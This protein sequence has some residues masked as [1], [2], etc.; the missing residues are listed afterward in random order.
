[1]CFIQG[2]NTR[3]LTLTLVLALLMIGLAGVRLTSASE[4]DV[5]TNSADQPTEL[6]LTFEVRIRLPFSER[7][8]L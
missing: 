7:E 4:T 6:I 1:M 3:N 2:M 5:A 8:I